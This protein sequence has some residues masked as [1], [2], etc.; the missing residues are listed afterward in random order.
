VRCVFVGEG[1]MNTSTC[2]KLS[3]LAAGLLFTMGSASLLAGPVADISSA[4]GNDLDV[5]VS[6]SNFSLLEGETQEVTITVT[7][8]VGEYLEW[9][10][11]EAL[12]SED[13]GNTSDASMPVL[14][15][16]G[17]S[18]SVEG[19]EL[20]MDGI[21][22]PGGIDN[23]LELEIIPDAG[24][25]EGMEWELT[26]E[27]AG[28]AWLDEFRM[29]IVDPQGAIVF[30]GGAAGARAAESDEQLDDD[31]GWPSTGGIGS[32]A[33]DIEDFN[34]T[35]TSGTEAGGT[36][37]VRLWNTFGSGTMGHL[38]DGSVL[39]FDVISE[40]V[41]PTF[42]P[43]GGFFEAGETVE[44]TIVS[45]V[46]DTTI[47][48][49]LDGSDPERDNGTAIDSGDT[50]TLEGSHNDTVTLKAFAFDPDDDSLDDSDITSA[51]F[52]FYEAIGIEDG[53]GSA[54]GDPEAGSG[55]SIVFVPTGGSGSYE[56]SALPNNVSGAEGVITE[57]AGSYSFEVP[58]EGAF[59]GTYTIEVVDSESGWVDTFD[60]TVAL[61]MDAEF[62]ELLINGDRSEVR[63]RGATPG[64][65]FT[66]S[67]EDEF[68]A[69]GSSIAIMDPE[70]AQAEDDVPSANPA[71]S[72]VVTLTVSELTVI[73]IRA[74]PE[75][76]TYDAAV[77]EGMSVHA[78]RTYSGWIRNARN[79]ELEDVYVAT[80]EEMGPENRHYSVWTDEDGVFRLTTPE[81]EA[82]DEH[83]LA[84]SKDGYVT[85][86]F[87]GEGCVGDEPQ[88]EQVLESASASITGMILGLGEGEEINL[89]LVYED[90]GDALEL[91]PEKVSGAGTGEDEWSLDANYQSMYPEI[92]ARGFGY[93][94]FGST[95]EG[96][97]FSF[98]EEGDSIE[99]VELQTV[100]TTPAIEAIR[101]TEAGNESAT[102]VVEANANERASMLTLSYGESSDNL[103]S[104][105]D[106]V[107]LAATDQLVAFALTIEGLSCGMEVFYQASVVNDRDNG[108]ESDV[109]SFATAECADDDGSDD[110]S[111]APPDDSRGAFLSCSMSNGKG[112]VDPLMPLL[113]LLAMVGLFT[114]RR[115]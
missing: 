82:E 64:Y 112:G 22:V 83:G 92:R 37:T 67:V 31:F 68:G 5:A 88:C 90:D 1:F 97:G 19:N 29:E 89:Y 65:G 10:F 7:D 46:D 94:P 23:A 13:S 106:E 100:P 103:E 102:I 25:I 15:S 6:P 12:L 35:G 50:V 36:W 42:D 39:E 73:R 109:N 57:D 8:P 75:D 48:Y 69:D 96:E 111:V 95:N 108:A 9:L 101:V 91:G 26:F 71:R 27:T 87:S 79:Q 47:H 77:H 114:R 14:L 115:V 34:G 104:G 38:L 66:F 55:D 98:E 84:A 85:R 105:L 17:V 43:D 86:L 21:E 93:E 44:V 30:A 28:L 11:G 33:R 78:G 99:G 61:E 60:I 24:F 4:T 74:T 32:D 72:A 80:R 49:T 45:T 107:N 70:Q 16:P 41:A 40:V 52:T 62:E 110:D 56:V 81:P 59:A 2:T 58:S 18:S 76:G 53:D 54:M 20:D 3:P 63:V 113:A 51:D